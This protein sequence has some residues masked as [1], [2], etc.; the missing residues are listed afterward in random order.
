MLATLT[1]NTAAAL[2]VPAPF[3]ITLAASASKTLPVKESDLKGETTGQNQFASREIELLRKKGD[4]TIVFA[5]EDDRQNV[6]GSA[7]PFGAGS[8][9]Q[10]GVEAFAAATDKTVTLLK[11]L[12][13]ANYKVFCTPDATTAVSLSP[14]VDTLAAGSFHIKFPVAF[15]GNVNWLLVYGA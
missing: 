2:I 3:G 14:W 5:A 12:P 15:T 1:N 7:K 11:P 9:V 10:A 4:L 8:F 13:S 6:E